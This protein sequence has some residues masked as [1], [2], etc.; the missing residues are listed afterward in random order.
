[1]FNLK[2]EVT[3]IYRTLFKKLTR[4]KGKNFLLRKEEAKVYTM[5][6]KRTKKK[7]NKKEGEAMEMLIYVR[8]RGKK[9]IKEA[10]V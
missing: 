9:G 10:E 7:K 5:S 8:P 1:M 2:T 4:E 6:K 3:Y